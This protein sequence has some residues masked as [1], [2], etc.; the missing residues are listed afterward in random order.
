MKHFVE[1][2]FPGVSCAGQ[3]ER[4]V[5]SR[6]ITEIGSLVPNY[7]IS[8]RFFSKDEDKNK[9]DFSSYYFFGKEYSAQEF[10]TKYP[11]LADDSDLA[12]AE[13]IVKATTGGFYPLSDKDIV[14]PV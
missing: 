12:S 1:F 8:C 3:N 14:V 10:K 4:E 7:A 2:Y 9:V 5:S 11:Q 6:D 13:R